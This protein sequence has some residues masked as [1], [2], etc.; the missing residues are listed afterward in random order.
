L[1]QAK[2]DLHLVQILHVVG[3]DLHQMQDFVLSFAFVLEI[4]VNTAAFF[5]PFSCLC[6]LAIFLRETSQGGA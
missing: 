1:H 6:L 4:E 2:T 5:R 3:I